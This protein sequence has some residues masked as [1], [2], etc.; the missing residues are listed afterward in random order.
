MQV[1]PY[2]RAPAGGLWPQA[3]SPGTQLP[4]WF[5]HSALPPVHP[6]GTLGSGCEY[7][8]ELFDLTQLHI[9]ISQPPKCL[10]S[11]QR[12]GDL[13]LHEDTAQ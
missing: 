8:L 2:P 10:L 1:R 7:E 11:S 9:T 4:I 6:L 13:G 3:L 5:S 12:Q